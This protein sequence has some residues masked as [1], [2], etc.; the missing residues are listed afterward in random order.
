MSFG[1][2]RRRIEERRRL[3][4]VKEQV[5]RQLAS[6]P[7]GRLASEV[8]RVARTGAAT[9]ATAERLRRQL[10]QLAAGASRS[11]V[12][13]TAV[14]RQIEEIE[15][16]ARGQGGL[17]NWLGQKLG[18]VADTIRGLL[19]P[20]GERSEA[21]DVAAA[22]ELLNALGVST[23]GARGRR[24]S[25]QSDDP[26]AKA[27]AERV[28]RGLGFDIQD[29]PDASPRPR[30]KPTVLPRD[31][32]RP[33]LPPDEHSG[34]V[35]KMLGGM[36]VY[37]RP[38]DPIITG[39]MIPVKSSNVHSIGFIWNDERPTDGTLKV[40]FLDSSGGKKTGKGGATYHYYDVHPR[41][42]IEFQKASS[43]GK[44]VWDKLRVRGT[45][46]GHQ[47]RYGLARLGSSGY[48]PRQATRIGNKEWYL[49]RSVQA[50]DGRTLKSALKDRMIRQL[51]PKQQTLPKS[52]FPNTR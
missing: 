22:A 29:A 24:V 34:M 51:T 45:V 7:I 16:Y 44:F 47:Y 37:F 40:R 27:D 41:V 19:K 14:A 2:I 30:P 10:D 9:K 11:A 36:F 8:D 38:D 31:R 13:R 48:V 17:W 18:P 42:F 4:R 49:Q 6:T 26:K 5:A 3:L 32:V 20:G 35:R 23:D 39:E 50:A 43:K 52:M 33:A 1:D 25:V 12:A 28:L 15:R 46:S 21:R